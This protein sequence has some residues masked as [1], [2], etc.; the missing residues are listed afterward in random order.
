ME[1]LIYLYAAV[2]VASSMVGTYSYW[3]IYS[4]GISKSL[5]GFP[6]GILSNLH[7]LK[8][9]RQ[10][11]EQSQK[12]DASDPKLARYIT[13]LSVVRKI[14]IILITIIV[15]FAAVVLVLSN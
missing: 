3:K 9:I 6:F 1:I 7:N 8:S 2:L 14:N 15:L 4:K 12:D 10:L 5:V 11:S 13:I